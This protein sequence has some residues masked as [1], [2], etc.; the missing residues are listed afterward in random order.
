MM[1]ADQIDELGRDLKCLTTRYNMLGK[2]DRLCAQA[3]LGAKA[4]CR[5]EELT[6]ALKRISEYPRAKHEDLGYRECKTIAREALKEPKCQQ[7]VQALAQLS[8]GTK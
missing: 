2:V 5:V 6:A 3:K 8:G 1:T 4:E 7:V